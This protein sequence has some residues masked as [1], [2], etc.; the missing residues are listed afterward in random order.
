MTL[1]PLLFVIHETNVSMDAMLELHEDP[2]FYGSYHAIISRE[3]EINF[4]VDAT[5][6]AYAAA[7]ST[8]TDSFGEVQ[9]IKGSVDDFAYHVALETPTD[10]QGNFNVTYHTGYT[11]EQYESLAWLSVSVGARK[12]RIVTH[13]EIKDPQDIEPRCFNMAHFMNEFINARQ[14]VRKTI[15]TGLEN[16]G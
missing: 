16:V 11:I 9:E 3:G 13:G 2:E 15:N 6:K 7:N 8:F 12:D 14:T 5:D 4:L 1:Y 10:A